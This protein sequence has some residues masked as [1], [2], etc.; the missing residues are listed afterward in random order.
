MPICLSEHTY[1]Q[2]GY[3]VLHF[4]EVKPL[5]YVFKS[6]LNYPHCFL[7]VQNNI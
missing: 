4:R 5:D 7:F 2:K 3:E 1:P 6:L